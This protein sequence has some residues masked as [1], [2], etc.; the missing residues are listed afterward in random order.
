LLYVFLSPTSPPA[1]LYPPKDVIVVEHNDFVHGN[2]RCSHDYLTTLG[3]CGNLKNVI[4]EEV[5]QSNP[6]G[7]GSNHNFYALPRNATGYYTSAD[8]GKTFSRVDVPYTWDRLKPHPTVG[9]LLLASSVV[10]VVS[11]QVLPPASNPPLLRGLV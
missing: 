8:G 3:D 11:L 4:I 6:H 5:Y 7:D 10:E 2:A 9:G 1:L